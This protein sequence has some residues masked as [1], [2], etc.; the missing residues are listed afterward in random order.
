MKQEPLC[1]DCKHFR[2]IS[3]ECSINPTISLVTGKTI[4]TNAHEYRNTSMLIACGRIG[5]WF[6]PKLPNEADLD[7]LSTIPF[8]R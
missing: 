4:Y 2:P 3:L 7:D 8:G 6:E 5:K 1:V